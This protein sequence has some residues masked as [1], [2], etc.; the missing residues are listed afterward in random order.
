MW[1][2]IVDGGQHKEMGGSGKT[3]IRDGSTLV[4]IPNNS[5]DFAMGSHY[6]EHLINPLQALY[7]LS[8]VLK[9]GGVIILILPQKE[10]CFDD[11]R[12]RGSME[13]MVFRF[14]HNISESDMNF[15][16]VEQATLQSNLARDLPAKN[17]GYFIGRSMQNNEL[18]GIH[19][20]V[21]DLEL[22]GKLLNIMGF[23]QVFSGVQSGLH[24]YVVGRK[25]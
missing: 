8:R 9:Q 21:Y 23:D 18:R 10:H 19:Q 13:D 24:Q 5:Y 14:L 16:H 15:A 11:K 17:Y 1:G 4:G 12:N 20:F 3:F 6:L 25:R 22:L 2:D 7:S